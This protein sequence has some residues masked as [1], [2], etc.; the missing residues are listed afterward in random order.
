MIK[1]LYSCLAW[2][3]YIN[4][5]KSQVSVRSRSSAHDYVPPASLQRR[6]LRSL[7]RFSDFPRKEIS[8]GEGRTVNGGQGGGEYRTVISRSTAL[9]SSVFKAPAESRQ[10]IN[11]RESLT[12]FQ[13]RRD[14]L[15]RFQMW[16]S[17]A[18]LAGAGPHVAGECSGGFIAI[19]NYGTSPALFHQSPDKSLSTTL[20]ILTH[21]DLLHIES[22]HYI[23]SLKPDV[24]STN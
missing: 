5:T 1:L 11:R 2:R 24:H 18:K 6:R 13:N 8:E 4:L 3:C 14:G 9:S 16:V 12:R 7:W 22:A 23:R 17:M 10:C 15:T 19:C 20:Y 21:T